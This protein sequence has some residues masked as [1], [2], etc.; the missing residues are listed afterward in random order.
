[1]PG[2][3]EVVDAT[4]I[5]AIE[6]VAWSSIDDAPDEDDTLGILLVVLVRWLL[7][8]CVEELPV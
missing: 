6:T 8:D 3:S 1:M 5:L 2:R 4:E 7:L